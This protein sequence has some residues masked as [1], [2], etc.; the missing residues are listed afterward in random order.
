MFPRW[1]SLIWYYGIVDTCMETGVNMTEKKS[2]TDVFTG[3]AS[4]AEYSASK[5]AEKAEIS[6][7]ESIAKGRCVVS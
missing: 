7:I 6:K 5:Q 3:K 2:L 4:P 1:I